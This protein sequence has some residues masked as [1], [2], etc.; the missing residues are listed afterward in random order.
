[1]KLRYL[2]LFFVACFL[3][4]IYLFPDRAIAGGNCDDVEIEA[5]E[6]TDQSNWLTKLGSEKKARRLIRDR[7]N[8][9]GN[10][11][12]TGRI[13]F[14][15]FVTMAFRYVFNPAKALLNIH[16]NYGDSVTLRLP[17]GRRVLFESRR[18]VVHEVLKETRETKDAAF[19]KSK[20]QSRGTERLF[21][22]NNVFIGQGE[23]WRRS[24][25]LM[26]EFF[27]PSFV[28]S[29]KTKAKITKVINRHVE[30]IRQQIRQS[31][32]SLKVDMNEVLATITLDVIL[33]VVLGIEVPTHELVNEIKPAFATANKWTPAASA[34]APFFNIEK[35]IPPVRKAHKILHD[36]T[37]RAI[38]KRLAHPTK[39]FDLLGINPIKRPMLHR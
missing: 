17:T 14:P 27:T 28:N 39:D 10:L 37:S 36:F 2:G 25:K 16:R 13:S 15:G 32:G 29:P 24:R 9:R 20:I 7:Q 12:G 1:M 31:Q 6:S 8:H 35:L 19:E 34:T 38:D 23:I 33:R 5:N 4:E 11:K 3:S 22:K 26:N 30:L 18:E 21:G